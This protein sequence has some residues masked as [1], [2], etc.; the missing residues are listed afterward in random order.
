MRRRVVVTGLGVVTP[1]G[2]TVEQFW[3]N[4]KNGVCGV[5]LTR[6]FDT[7]NFAVKVSAEVKE[8]DETQYM[9]KKMAKRMDRFSQFAISAAGQAIEQAGL[10]LEK[11]DL[12]RFGVIIGS[13]IGSLGTM[14]SEEQR[15]LEYGPTRVSPMLI[16]KIITNMAAGNVA[17]RFG[18]KGICTCVVTACASG[19]N[20]IGEAFRAIQYGSNDV[21]VAGG[22]ESSVTPLGIA[23]FSALSA[24][25]TTLDPLQ[26]SKPFDKN[27]NGFVLGEGAGVIVLE[28][29]EHA[30]KRGAT[31]LAEVAGYGATCDAHHITSPDPEGDGAKRSME[32]AILDA[33]I[34]KEDISY[35]NAHG[36]STEYNDKLE[37]LAIKRLF[38]EGA[39]KIPVNSTKS[40]IG[41]LLGAAGGVES[42][43]CVKSVVE[44]YVHPTIGYSEK[45]EECDLDYVPNIGRQHVV[46]YAM[47]NS[48]GFGGHN[49]TLVFKKFTD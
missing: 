22:T 29:L 27:R 40:M 48:L 38:E 21:I 47:T 34:Q 12:T 5:G 37:T 44:D 46:N 43:V 20:S 17:I 11:E 42:V 31:I 4:L 8:F 15:L 23:G 19:T 45:D 36:T 25:S 32:Q 14:E 30:I 39:Y 3:N 24:L 35:I 7:S 6:A 28:E 41:H 13:G 33:G 26:A 10:E 2:N 18:F 49:A 16:P 1:V 9:D